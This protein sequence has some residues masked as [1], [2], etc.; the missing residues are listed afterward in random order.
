MGQLVD[1]KWVSDDVLRQHDEKGL[2]FKRA[3]VFRHQVTADGSSGFPAQS[4]R[5]HLYCAVAC[6]WAHRA[7]LFRVLKGLVPH[8]TL[9]NA[10]QEVGGEGW[11][12]GPE[13]HLAPGTDRR[14]RW[15]HELYTV[16]DP[17]C[18]TRVTVPTLWDAQTQR[19]VNNESS[20]IIRLFNTAF[21]AITGRTHDYYPSHLRAEIDET[22]AFVLRGI[23]N[24][25]NGCGYSISQ[26]AYD[27]QV[28]LLFATLDRLEERLGRQ[29]Y[30]CGDAQTEADWRLFPSLVRF[31]AIYYVAYKC[32]L[33]RLEDYHNLSN[34][35]RELYQTPGIAAA[36]DIAGM[37]RGVYSKAGPVGA[38]GIVPTGPVVDH[39]RP[40]DRAR[41]PIRADEL[42]RA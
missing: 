14:V 23:N 3:A 29:R 6:P 17:S 22:N 13:G 19:I 28:Q 37:K 24:A 16:A 15:L 35:L 11:G 1:G 21:G 31:D 7:V 9:W 8:V 20:E 30:L 4:G 33:R 12:F 2:Y 25:V 34:Y 38:N 41:P 32:N 40:H 18:T 26:Q 42:A 5:Y 10:A 39:S 27:E 36:C